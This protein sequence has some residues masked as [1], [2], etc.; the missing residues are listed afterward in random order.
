MSHICGGWSE[1][2]GLSEEEYQMVCSLA[3]QVHHQIGKT[4]THFTP[5][6]SKKQVV[7]GLN[8][9]VKIQVDHGEHDYIHVKIFKPLPHTGLPAEV[10][11]VHQGK[12]LH[13]E[14]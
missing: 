1:A 4:T 10:K 8:Y 12:T 9:F 7:A 3:E 2:S 11:E 14:L 13:D 6:A 5:V